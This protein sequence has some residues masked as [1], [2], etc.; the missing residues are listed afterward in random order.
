MKFSYLKLVFFQPGASPIKLWNQGFHPLAGQKNR[1]S[2]L[3]RVWSLTSN[4]LKAAPL[5]AKLMKSYA[6]LAEPWFCPQEM[7]GGFSW[8]WVYW[9]KWKFTGL[10]IKHEKQGKSFLKLFPWISCWLPQ[11]CKSIQVLL[12]SR[13]FFGRKSQVKLEAWQS[14]I[15]SF[16]GFSSLQNGGRT[17]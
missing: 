13:C 10:W 14:F 8:W 4:D 1:P 16:G 5:A 3:Q 12:Q 9:K 7:G 2:R 17:I 15:Q 6:L 11:F